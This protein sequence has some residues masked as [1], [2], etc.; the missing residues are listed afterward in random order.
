MRHLA[1]TL[2][3]IPL[4]IFLIWGIDA[5]LGNHLSAEHAAYWSICLIIFGE[6]YHYWRKEE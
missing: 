1:L 4:L 6:T 5:E 3:V 2:G